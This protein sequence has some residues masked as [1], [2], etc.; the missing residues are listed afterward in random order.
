VFSGPDTT[1]YVTVDSENGASQQIAVDVG[2]GPVEW[3]NN[4]YQIALW[5][6][7]MGA[8]VTWTSA[9]G[10]GSIVFPTQG[11]FGQ[12]GAL[13]GFTVTTTAQDLALISLSTMPV[14][15]GYRG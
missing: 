7:S 3:T 4:S 10:S 9:G 1:I 5:I 12:N 15:A 8:V 2:A 14:D 13:V 11:V 6:N